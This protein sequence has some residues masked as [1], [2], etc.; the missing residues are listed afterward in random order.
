MHTAGRLAFR[1]HRAKLHLQDTW[2]W[3]TD[4]RAASKNLKTLADAPA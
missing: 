3:A 4:L 2:P 1:G